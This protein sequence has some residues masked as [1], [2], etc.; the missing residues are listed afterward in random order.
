MNTDFTQL[1]FESISLNANNIANIEQFLKNCIVQSFIIASAN[2]IS[3][4]VE[5]N[6]AM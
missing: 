1:G 3:S 6:S 4:K 5:L 2:I